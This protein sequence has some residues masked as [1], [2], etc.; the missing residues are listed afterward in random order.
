MT[1]NVDIDFYDTPDL[2]S[3]CAINKQKRNDIQR[4]QTVMRRKQIM[5]AEG[6]T[7]VYEI[8]ILIAGLTTGLEVRAQESRLYLCHHNYNFIPRG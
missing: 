4:Q 3:S 7:K 1:F 8:F 6:K 5:A 2:S